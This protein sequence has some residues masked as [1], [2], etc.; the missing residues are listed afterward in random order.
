MGRTT[1][2][3]A[4]HSPKCLSPGDMITRI[5]GLPGLAIHDYTQP[6]SRGPCHASPAL[7]PAPLAEVRGLCIR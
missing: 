6:S 5:S 2:R 3:E 7:A 4:A 1:D